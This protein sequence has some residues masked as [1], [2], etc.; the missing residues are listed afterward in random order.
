MS[1][2]LIVHCTVYYDYDNSSVLLSDNIC[3]LPYI[4]FYLF[5]TYIAIHRKQPSKSILL[6]DYLLDNSKSHDIVIMH[7]GNN[8]FVARDCLRYNLY[9]TL[10][11]KEN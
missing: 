11:T 6:A 1:Y 3:T 10:N 9:E 5:S 4:E 2:R 7:L 8:I